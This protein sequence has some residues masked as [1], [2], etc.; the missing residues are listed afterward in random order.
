[1]KETNP[2]EYLLLFIHPT[3]TSVGSPPR[4]G[5]PALPFAFAEDQ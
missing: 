3:G 2:Y 4:R 5:N 1:V